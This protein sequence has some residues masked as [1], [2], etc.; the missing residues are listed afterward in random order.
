MFM[1]ADVIMRGLDRLEDLQTWVFPGGVLL[2][3]TH[4]HIVSTE[5]NRPIRELAEDKGAE[6][7]RSELQ[8]LKLKAD[9]CR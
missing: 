1:F 8:H 6:L 9:T 3:W 5:A 4:H 2:Q 7:Q